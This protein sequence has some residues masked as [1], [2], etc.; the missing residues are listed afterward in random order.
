MTFQ[1]TPVALLHIKNCLVHM[2]WECM[3]TVVTEPLTVTVITLKHVRIAWCLEPGFL[4]LKHWLAK[5]WVFYKLSTMLAATIYLQ[6]Y[7]LLQWI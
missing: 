5:Q 1:A 6:L 2:L 3:Q 4:R 7:V